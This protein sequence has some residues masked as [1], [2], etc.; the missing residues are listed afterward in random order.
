[1]LLVCFPQVTSRICHPN[2]IV[3]EGVKAI[4]VKVLTTYPQQAMWYILGLTQSLNT[5]RKTRAIDIFK[6]AQKHLNG[7]N[8]V[9]LANGLLEGMKLVEELIKL[10]EH[11]PGN[12][13]KMQV[14]LSRVRA[15]LLVPLQ[16]AFSKTSS[17][18][19]ALSSAAA[20]A[21]SGGV[22]IKTFGDKA[23]VMLT[24]EKPKRIQI[25][26]SD[27][28]W[29]AFL[30]KRE[31]HGDLRK[32]ARMMEFNAIMNKLLQADADGRRRKL[33]LRTYAVIC[34]NEESGLMEWV[35]N[36]R[37]MRHLISQI[38]KTELGF[39]QPVRLTTELKDAFLNMQ[40]QFAHDIPRM[41]LYY[42]TH[43]LS[44]PAFVPRFH[45]WFLNNFSDPT[46]WF[47]AR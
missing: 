17:S 40:K 32:D 33:R 1:M 35:P 16:S 21:T 23:D 12:Q 2:P 9:E 43:I 10:A 7:S 31:K 34:L 45:Q 27:G 13:R 15:Q 4:M 42:K 3:V 24:K 22:Y 39:L 46:A 11:D 29:Y 18:F 8:Q 28:Q 20:S 44:H 47:E 30:C 36:T 38:Y 14:R 41:A 26:G 37:A 6:I 19:T 25:L 5:Q